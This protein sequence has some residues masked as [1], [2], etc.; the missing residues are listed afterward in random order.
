MKEKENKVVTTYHIM[1]DVLIIFYLIYPLPA[2]TEDYKILLIMH[3]L[4]NKSKA[5]IAWS[6]G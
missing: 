1:Q 2:V 4:G 5:N 3:S 6:A